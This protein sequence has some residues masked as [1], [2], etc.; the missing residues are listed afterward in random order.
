MKEIN[1]NTDRLIVF[2]YPE[3]AGGKFIS[4]CLALSPRVLH[5]D[6]RL[7]KIKMRGLM[8]NERSFLTGKTVLTKSKRNNLDWHFELG[9]MEL[10]GFGDGHDST[11]NELWVELTNQTQ[12][13]FCMMSH[14]G[15]GYNHYPEA[16]HIIF[17]GYDWIL[18]KRNKT[19]SN[20]NLEQNKKREKILHFDQGAIKDHLL[21]K[22][23]IKHLY[24]F[25]KFDEPNWEHIEELR[26][27]WLDTFTP[28]FA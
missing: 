3:G 1:R 19:I 17:K 6:Q 8:N 9:C 4:L 5:Q 21:F 26:I 22:K 13:Y 20:I 7:A 11:A 24:N 18:E 23:E 16:Y 25:F 28:G 2:N 10:A 27:I 14:T 12:F 15:N